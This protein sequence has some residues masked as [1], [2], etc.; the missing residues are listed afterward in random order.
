MKKLL[1]GLGSLILILAWVIGFPVVLFLLAGN[2]FPTAAQWNAII[3]LTPD[4]GNIILFTKVLPLLL[5]V[6]WAAF[7]APFLVELFASFRGVK[8]RKKFRATRWQQNLSAGLI[9]AVA[10]TFAGLGGLSGAAPA[11]AATVQSVSAGT[12]ASAPVVRTPIQQTPIQ[13]QAPPTVHDEQVTV[14]EGDTLFGISERVTG[15]GN[16]YPEIVEATPGVQPDGQTLTDPDLIQPGWV[17][18]V[19][20]TEAAAPAAPAPAPVTPAPAPQTSTSPDGVDAPGALPPGSVDGGSAGAGV[21]SSNVAATPSPSKAPEQAPPIE[22]PAPQAVAPVTEEAEQGIDWSVPLM[23]AGGI[24]GILAAG[25][26]SA[27][28]VRR[29]QQRRRR[30]LDERIA[31]PEGDAQRMELE[32]EYISDPTSVDDVDNSL[33]TLQAWA[34][35]TGAELPEL[36]AV[37]VADEEVAL[38]LAGPAQ[39]PEPF[40][41]VSDDGTAWIVRPGRAVAPPRPTVSPYPALATIGTDANGGFLL[42]DLE[43]IGSLNV[44]G[45]DEIAVGMLNALA[46][47]LAQNPWSEDIQVTLVGMDDALAWKLNRARIQQVAD[48]PALVRN[49]RADMEDRREALDSYGVGGVLEARTRATEMESWAPHIVIL[50]EPPVGALRDE[51]AELVERMPRLGIATVSHGAPLVDGA[52]INVQSAQDAEYCSGG[53]MPPMPF[54]PQILAG[55]ELDAMRELF[56]VTEQAGHVVDLIAE[57]P[58]PAEAEPLPATEAMVANAA[59]ELVAQ[60]D[61]DAA[62]AAAA[63]ETTADAEESHAPAEAAAELEGESA[64]MVVVPDWPAPMIRL[65]G[66]VDAEGIADPEALPG[67]GLELLA[68]LLLQN[69]PVAGSFVQSQL[70]PDKYDP[71]NG[72][73][74]TLAKQVRGA[75]GHDPDGNPLLPEGRASAGFSAHPAMTTDWHVFCQLIGP[76]LKTTSNENLLAAVRLVRGIPFAGVKRQRGWWTWQRNWEETMRQAIVDAAAELAHRALGSSRFDDAR[77]AARAAQAADPLVETGWRLEIETAMKA[78]DADAFNRVVEE[79]YERIGTDTELDDETVELIDAAHKVLPGL[80]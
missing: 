72:N 70:W 51:L 32:T 57:H 30:A 75:L 39:L 63:A 21:G 28:S 44:N 35:E 61:E 45:D 60:D 33:R 5:W 14:Q 24:G 68:F 40:E 48:V 76:D 74:R 2:P 17:V 11:N 20:V 16:N 13:Q 43:Q 73:A 41:S 46:S 8:T 62:D 53:A 37:R 22:R 1:A 80:S 77:T 29:T 65:L 66:P 26:L 12:V 54:R 4:Y 9:G 50:A 34:E 25:L 3:T 49:L 64:P 69:G 7:T 42:L 27:L 38:Y 67:R 79:M 36:V 18:N 47:E 19:P 78:G 6:I 56:A 23:T 15:D 10:L 31:L 71:K 58:Q 52:T 59:A 55:Q